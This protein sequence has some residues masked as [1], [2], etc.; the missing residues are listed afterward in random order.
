M[1]N[2]ARACFLNTVYTQ[3]HAHTAYRRDRWTDFDAQCVIRGCSE[4]GS[5]FW[6]LENLIF[7]LFIQ[8][9]QKI[10]MAPMGKI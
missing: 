8:Q 7:N 9:I 6:G 10:T 1:I 5:A 2:N 3:S 4:Q